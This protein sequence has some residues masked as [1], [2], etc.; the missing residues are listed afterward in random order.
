VWNGRCVACGSNLARKDWPTIEVGSTPFVLAI[1]ESCGTE[2]WASSASDDAPDVSVYWEGYKAAVD[3]S[4]DVRDAFGQRYKR[5]F[6]LTAELIG[7][8]H[9]CLDIGGGSGNFALWAEGERSLWTLTTDV[10]RSAIELARSRG[11]R[12]TTSAETVL[13]LDGR[14]V[15]VVTLWDVIEHVSDPRELL[16]QTQLALRPGGALIIETP[17]AS[18]VGRKLARVLIRVTRRR[19]DITGPLYYWEH[20]IY[21]TEAG[22]RQLCEQYGMTVAVCERWTSP[23]AKMVK[24]MSNEATRHRRGTRQMFYAAIAAFYPTVERVMRAFGRGGCWP[25]AASWH[26]TSPTGTTSSG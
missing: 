6:D 21:Y 20:K 4:A 1:C 24:L 8:P 9:T 15:D 5:A 3:L 7:D 19:I 26:F 12:A 11:V 10:D 13:E 18:F 23:P 16:E 14:A 22:L 25:L 2:T 17:D